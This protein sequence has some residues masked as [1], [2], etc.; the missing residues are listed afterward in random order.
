MPT[1]T[2]VRA[3]VTVYLFTCVPPPDLCAARPLAS[4]LN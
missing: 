3:C 1:V 4:A 2:Y